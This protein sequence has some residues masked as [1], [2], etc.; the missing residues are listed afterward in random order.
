MPDNAFGVVEQG[1]RFAQLRAAVLAE[2]AAHARTPGFIARDIAP[3]PEV[4]ASG[5]RFA[6]AMRVVERP[7]EA[8]TIEHAMGATAENALRFRALADQERAMLREFR[9]VAQDA[10]R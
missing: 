10:R 5:V 7:G 3:E 2:D 4:T 6:A 9:T 1:L 8:G